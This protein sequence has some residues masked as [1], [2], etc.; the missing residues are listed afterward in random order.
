MIGKE[1]VL[2]HSLNSTH[3]IINTAELFQRKIINGTTAPH[4]IH[5]SQIQHTNK[6]ANVSVTKQ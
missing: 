1:V 4:T 5:K 6:Q 3:G 2:F